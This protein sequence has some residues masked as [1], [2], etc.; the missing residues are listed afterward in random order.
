MQKK[1]YGQKMQSHVVNKQRIIPYVIQIP[2]SVLP[3]GLGL[4]RYIFF[5][6]EVK[7]GGGG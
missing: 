1:M 2:N 7:C 3:L 5:S 6:R 4:L